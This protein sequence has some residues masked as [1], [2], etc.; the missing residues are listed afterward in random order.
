MEKDYIEI[1]EDNYKLEILRYEAFVKELII[2]EKENKIPYE[3]VFKII[4]NYHSDFTNNNIVNKGDWEKVTDIFRYRNE[5]IEEGLEMDVINENMYFAYKHLIAAE[6]PISYEYYI[7]CLS[8]YCA[9]SESFYLFQSQN[10]LYSFMYK[11]NDFSKFKIFGYKKE[12]YQILLKDYSYRAKGLFFDE[13]VDVLIQKKGIK[14]F[15]PEKDEYKE[16]FKSEKFYDFLVLNNY[17]DGF[18]SEFLDFKNVFLNNFDSNTSFIQFECTT[19]K[20]AVLLN[21]LKN[22]F[23]KKLTFTN[24]QLSK[25]FKSLRGGYLKRSNISQAYSKSTPELIKEVIND[26]DLFMCDFKQ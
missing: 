17:V 14:N 21:E 10:S 3:Q 11:L 2:C 1:Y 4:Q 16:L 7:K 26:L 15:C 13:E 25:K 6:N 5:Y 19:K 18:L 22:R 23:N 24:I 9:H 12:F 20:A 8:K